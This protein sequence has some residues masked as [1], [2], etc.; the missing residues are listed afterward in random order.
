MSFVGKLKCPQKCHPNGRCVELVFGGRR[1]VCNPGFVGDGIECSGESLCKGFISVY[2]LLLNS[3]RHF[4]NEKGTGTSQI[5]QRLL[6][7]FLWTGKEID[8]FTDTA[9]I[10]N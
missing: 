10:L 5:S 1:C 2:H 4:R 7:L 8:L 6:G 9:A 3:R